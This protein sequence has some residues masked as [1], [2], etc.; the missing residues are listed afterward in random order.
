M[1][2]AKLAIQSK[3]GIREGTL[4]LVLNGPLTLSNLFEF[5]S[6]VRASEAQ[7]LIVD[8]SAVPYVDSAGIGCLVGGH[9]SHQ[10]NQRRFSLVGVNDRVRTILNITGVESLFPIFATI[11]QAEKDSS[12]T[13]TA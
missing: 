4:I 6:L 8:L 13:A 12:G 2:D 1:P 5:Q 11:D 3:P 10:R 9:I 7:S